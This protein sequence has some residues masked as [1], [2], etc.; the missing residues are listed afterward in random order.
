M[1][2]NLEKVWP[3]LSGGS[4]LRFAAKTLDG[5]QAYHDGTGWTCTDP[6][7]VTH[8]LFRTYAPATEIL[9]EF[10][11]LPSTSLLALKKKHL[12]TVSLYFKRVSVKVFFT[13]FDLVVLNDCM[14][15]LVIQLTLY[16][17]STIIY[18]SKSIP[19]RPSLFYNSWKCYFKC[20]LWRYKQPYA[21]EFGLWLFRQVKRLKV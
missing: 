8:F 10:Y 4:I 2:T 13:G 14:E 12:V 18:F 20:L 5:S 17:Y 19:S 6:T 21:I 15:C 1:V 9:P 3:W 11:R 16:I 7:L